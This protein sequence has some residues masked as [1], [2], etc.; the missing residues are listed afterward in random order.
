MPGSTHRKTMGI[1]AAL[2]GLTFA[3]LPV[4]ADDA[5]SANLFQTKCAACHGAD[6]AG[7]TTV[8][9]TLMVKDLR[10]PEIQKATDDAL[11]MIITKGKDK[12]PA[13]EKSLKPDDIKGLVAFIRSLAKK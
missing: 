8:G 9:K 6:G 1:A 11:T 5:A 12:M 4:R 7:N 13:Y 3:Y 10:D 2:L